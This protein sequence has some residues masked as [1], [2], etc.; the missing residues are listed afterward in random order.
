M[1]TTDNTVLIT[2]GSA[3]IG[4]EIAKALVEKGNKVIIT[5]RDA[6]RLESAQKQ[7]KDAVVI[8]FDVTDAQQ[9]E[10]LVQRL[11][12]EFPELNVVVNNAGKAFLHHLSNNTNS[13][14]AASEEILTNY[15]SIVRLNEELLPLLNKQQEGAI[16]NVSSMVAFAPPVMLSTYAASKA[17]LHSY[18]QSLRLTLSKNTSIRVF[19]LIPPL[20]NTA[21]SKEIG[22]GQGISPAVVA[23]ELLKA[24]EREEHEI[25]VGDTAQISALSRKSPQEALM[26]MNQSFLN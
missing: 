4:F 22:G 20:V 5:G 9:V 6:S 15:L 14:G 24:M 19:E 21:F 25:H 13:F 23:E 12:Q 16:V 10:Q 26:V 18:T 8:P 17:A 3:G 2:G 7:L 11:N 1:K